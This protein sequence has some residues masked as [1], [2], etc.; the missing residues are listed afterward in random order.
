MELVQA[1]EQLRL[2]VRNNLTSTAIE[3][4]SNVS[5][6]CLDKLDEYEEFQ[7][8]VN[9][10]FAQISD[11]ETSHDHLAHL[12]PKGHF[13]D[14]TNGKTSSLTQYQDR[15]SIFRRPDQDRSIFR[16]SQSS[17]SN[18]NTSQED[19]SSCSS[20][21]SGPSTSRCPITATSMQS[22]H[23]DLLVGDLLR[24]GNL[25]SITD[26]MR[27]ISRILAMGKEIEAIYAKVKDFISCSSPQIIDQV[28]ARSLCETF[29]GLCADEP[30]ISDLPTISRYLACCRPILNT[31]DNSG[32]SK[33]RSSFNDSCGQMLQD[34]VRAQNNL[35]IAND[36]DDDMSAMID[37]YGGV[38]CVDEVAL[39]NCDQRR[40]LNWTENKLYMNQE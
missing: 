31:L 40:V 37:D 19:D 16:F 14:L 25:E 27:K 35:I 20:Q 32:L 17:G 12:G 1:L 6:E 39:L 5:S 29:M 28:Y 8:S 30:N 23:D 21:Q 11:L 34:D 38:A 9:T 3:N 4:N 2:E 7:R 15:R 26:T 13:P 22:I 18:G 10:L 24:R 36:N 33:Q